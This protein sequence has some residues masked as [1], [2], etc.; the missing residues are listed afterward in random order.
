MPLLNREMLRNRQDID[1]SSLHPKASLNPYIWKNNK[2]D[3]FVRKQL[4]K[5]AKDF[6]SSFDV[7]DFDIKDI[8]ITGSIANYNWN[9]ENSDIDLHIIVDFGD[10]DDNEDLVKAFFDELRS[11]WNLKHS[12]IRVYGYPVEIY[13][14]DKDE[15]HSSSG[16]Y[17]IL[18]DEWIIEPSVEKMSV[19]IDDEKVKE[20]ADSFMRQIDFIE[21]RFLLITDGISSET[22]ENV[23]KDA[24]DL[25]DEI[26]G[27]R[28]KEVKSK[29]FEL[30][31][32]NLVFKVLRRNGYIGKLNDI[33]TLAYDY[34]NS[35]RNGT[36][37]ESWQDF[38]SPKSGATI[39]TVTKSAV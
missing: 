23:L 33:R 31:T 8:V 24:N 6:I 2:L 15:E 29:S 30:S 38:S 20:M 5:I 18:T 3:I 32:G 35:L 39:F 27:T 13:V 26:K 14:Q 1:T 11:N 37:R 19:E 34:A 12:G 25:F 4:L 10:V 9:E 28:R 22:I 17:S 16:V 21:E 7:S 36:T